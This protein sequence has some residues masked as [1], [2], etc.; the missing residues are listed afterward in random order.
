MGLKNNI[1]L[2]L[3]PYLCIGLYGLDTYLS[4]K[5]SSCMTLDEAAYAVLSMSESQ[6]DKAVQSGHWVG[7]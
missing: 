3:K 6:N 5:T 7:S 2:N 1:L 4:I